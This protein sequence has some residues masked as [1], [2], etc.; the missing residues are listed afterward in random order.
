[1]SAMA[2]QITSLTIVYSTVYSGV[3]QRRHQSSESLAFVPW[4]HRWPVNSP[5]K[6]PVTRQMFPFDGVIMKFS[7]RGAVGRGGEASSSVVPPSQGVLLWLTAPCGKICRRK[8]FSGFNWFKQNL[9]CPRNVRI[10]SLWDGELLRAVNHV[11]LAGIVMAIT[12]KSQLA[13]AWPGHSLTW[14][15][16]VIPK[17]W[18]LITK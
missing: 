8:F 4:I 3:D 6:G 9:V 16:S 11:A 5:H 13:A 10:P 17:G 18:C 14:M 2:S 1:M 15:V 7:S 12:V